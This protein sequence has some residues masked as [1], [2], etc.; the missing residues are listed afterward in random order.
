MAR[1][2]DPDPAPGSI[3]KDPWHRTTAEKRVSDM[4]IL[5]VTGSLYPQP[6]NNAII[7][8]K[9]IPYLSQEHT[10]HL[11]GS[12]SADFAGARPE[13]CF[14]VPTHWFDTNKPGVLRRA[15][16]RLKDK[17]LDPNGYSDA[18][19]SDTFCRRIRELDQEFHYDAVVSTLEP[20]SGALAVSR[21]PKTMHRVVYLM[22][23]P[24]FLVSGLQDTSFREKNMRRVVENSEAVLTT[25]AIRE[26]LLDAYP[27]Q[28]DKLHTVGFPLIRPTQ[29]LNPEHPIQIDPGKINLL[30]CG[31][32]YGGMR[33]PVYFLNLLSALDDRFCVYFIGKKCELLF[34][35]Y[36]IHTAAKVVN[37]PQQDYDT[38]MQ[39]MLDADVLINIGNS[40]P[41]HMPSKLI[42]YF[43]AGKPI[44]NVAKL[45]NC[46]SLHFTRRYPRC[47]DLSEG[48]DPKSAA[49]KLLRFCLE[50][51]TAEP[52]SY[53]ETARIFP[54]CTPQY[55]A[56]LLARLCT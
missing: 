10:V 2:T 52:I 4:K 20:F 15:L 46:P 16:N 30:Y 29:A 21:L 37:L 22:D 53:D 54:E 44:V 47:L 1:G 56:E 3:R 13:T 19:A 41:V 26:V 32:L 35:R 18:S 31:W 48:E 36:Q 38:A 40:V 39:A 28:R 23:P 12:V 51:K 8:S 55:I 42:E 14:G 7:I 5:I 25:E 17:L 43:N 6:S 11:L 49:E 27:D 34:E 50:A 24:T 33:S 9:I 45:D